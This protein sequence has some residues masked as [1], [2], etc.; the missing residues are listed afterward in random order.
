MPLGLRMALPRDRSRSQDRQPQSQPPAGEKF[1]WVRN[2][3]GRF[4]LVVFD[5]PELQPW[6]KT[7][8]SAVCGFLEV[9]KTMDQFV[10]EKFQTEQEVR[11]WQG[12]IVSDLLSHKTYAARLAVVTSGKYRG[13]NALGVST[14]GYAHP[15]M[16]ALALSLTLA[17][18]IESNVSE[19]DL[20]N[21]KWW[22][23]VIPI[24]KEVR[25]DHG[26]QTKFK[27]VGQRGRPAMIPPTT[28]SKAASPAVQQRQ[29]S[30]I[31]IAVCPSC[32]HRFCPV[33]PDS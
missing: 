19:A 27:E 21:P 1:A 28:T 13:I 7:A 9:G 26:R 11:A 16:E 3:A 31:G 5:C 14:E 2:A 17:V 25:D 29:M 10:V 12:T 30:R 4:I 23:E 8:K 15:A 18:C 22:P 24:F 20:S 33:P 6:L 32:G